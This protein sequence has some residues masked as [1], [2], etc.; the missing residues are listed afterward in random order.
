MKTGRFSMALALLVACGVAQGAEIAIYSFEDSVEGWAVPE[1]AKT[2]SD[3]V[4]RDLS[5]SDEVALEGGHALEFW[6]DFPGDRWAGAYIERTLDVNDWTSFGRVLVSVYLPATAPAGLKGRMIL[7]V[8]DDWQWAEMNRGV[9]LAPGAWTTITANLT[10]TSMDWKFFP[11]EQFR[12]HVDKLGIRI[13]S[14]A[15]GPVYSGPIFVDH[16]RLAE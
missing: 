16:V 4:A 8:G 13:E 5:V 11:D 2:S 10:P 9:A 3:Y 14:E 15:T 1:W 12:K 6:S 7:T